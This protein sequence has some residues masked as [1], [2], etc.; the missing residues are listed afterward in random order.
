MPLVTKSQFEIN[1]QLGMD[2]FQFVIPTYYIKVNL[3]NLKEF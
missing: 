2:G 3:L 1:E